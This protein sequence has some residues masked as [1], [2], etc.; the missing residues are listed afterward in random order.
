MVAEKV[1][2]S[3]KKVKSSHK[4]AKASNEEV[5]IPYEEVTEDTCLK[6]Y[7]YAR[8]L[9]KYHSLCPN[10]SK[11]QWGRVD[12]KGWPQHVMFYHRKT[13]SEAD[14]QS[15]LAAMPNIRL[16]LR[17]SVVQNLSTVAMNELKRRTQEFFLKY[18]NVNDFDWHLLKG[19]F[20]NL[21]FTHYHMSKW[22]GKDA[23]TMEEI[24]KHFEEKYP[25]GL[26]YN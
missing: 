24:L 6:E 1:K 23:Q 13:W 19:E 12:V 25:D 8:I 26:P 22:T 10:V 11:I 21:H 20:P 16:Y 15:L 7:V 3:C 4:K 14:C 17:R 18:F 5:N 9:A 2:N